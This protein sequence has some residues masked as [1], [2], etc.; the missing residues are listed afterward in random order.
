MCILYNN[1]F[2]NNLL[3]EYPPTL[4]FQ[5]GVYPIPSITSRLN[6]VEVIGGID[7]SPRLP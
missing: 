5:G 3:G 7:I 2:N 4:Y 6:N 1:L